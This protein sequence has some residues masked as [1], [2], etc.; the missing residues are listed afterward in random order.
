VSSAIE[1]LLSLGGPFHMTTAAGNAFLDGRG[2]M[3]IGA[4]STGRTR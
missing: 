1:Y 2:S 4:E 3:K